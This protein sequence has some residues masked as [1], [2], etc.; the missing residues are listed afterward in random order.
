[1]EQRLPGGRNDGAVRAGRTVRRRT[2]AHT[3]A[4]HALLHHL[5]AVGFSR[6][7]RVLGIDERGRE[8][9]GF[10]DGETVGEA[11]PW[12]AWAH[13]DAALV[14]AGTW[15]RDFHAAAASFVPPP[16]AH[17][18]GGRDE[19]RPGEVV[20]H[21]DAAPYNAVW[22]PGP[23]PEDPQAGQLVGFVD[24]DL[25]GPAEPLRDL[26]FTVLTWVPLTAH[27]VAAADGFPSG[28]GAVA[29]RA[30][31]LRLLLRAYGWSGGTGA[32]LAAVHRRAVEH[33][34]GLRAAAAGGYAPA[35]AL[36]AEGVA[37]DFERAAAQLD[38]DAP[39]LL[40]GSAGA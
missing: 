33:A 34:A 6:A 3:P 21:H 35:V 10:L 2:G 9:L 15:M 14:A 13:G 8:V 16:D 11:R 1:M 18:S 23:T 36:V 30:R 39:E 22:N 20:G 7:P 19:V 17:W 5:H 28:A 29:E 25:A 4:V 31:R 32:V 40:A 38:A 27:D 12:P 37:D 26:A 24:W